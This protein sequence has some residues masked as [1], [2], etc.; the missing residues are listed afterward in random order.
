LAGDQKAAKHVR[1]NL[2][3]GRHRAQ[4]SADKWKSNVEARV[5]LLQGIPNARATKSYGFDF[6]SATWE[7]TNVRPRTSLVYVRK[8]LRWQQQEREMSNTTSLRVKKP[9]AV[10][11]NLHG[12]LRAICMGYGMLLRQEYQGIKIRNEEVWGSAIAEMSRLGYIVL[13]EKK[14]DLEP[15]MH[16]ELVFRLKRVKHSPI[17]VP[18]PKMHEL[19]PK[20]I[21]NILKPTLENG[22]LVWH[23]TP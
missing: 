10:Q 18:G 19:Y 20:L 17:W 1:A 12:Y 15:W 13:V 7:R 16:E 23:H 4:S 8:A 11:A 2:M 6:S 9:S 21:D 3:L 5:D 14:D 22:K